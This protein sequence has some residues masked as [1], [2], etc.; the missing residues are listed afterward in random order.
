MAC[1]W[2]IINYIYRAYYDYCEKNITNLTGVVLY[3]TPLIYKP[4]LFSRIIKQLSKFKHYIPTIST[5]LFNQNQEYLK[6]KSDGLDRI[7][8]KAVEFDI[9]TQLHKITVPILLLSGERDLEVSHI[10]QQMKDLITN[11]SEYIIPKTGHNAHIQNPTLFCGVVNKWIKSH[12]Q[13][14]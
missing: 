7:Y 10:R 5:K 14:N 11:S 8:R 2:Y 13:N 12:E 9:T 6:A 4:K 1:F 3:G